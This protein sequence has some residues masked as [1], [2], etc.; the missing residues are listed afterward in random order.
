MSGYKT[1]KI[2][3]LA[4]FGLLLSLSKSSGLN[5]NDAKGSNFLKDTEEIADKTTPLVVVSANPKRE[6][7][8]SFFDRIVASISESVDDAFDISA[9]ILSGLSDI[10]VNIAV[11]IITAI[12]ESA[13][14]TTPGPT[15]NPI[16]SP[17]QTEAPIDPLTPAP[18][19]TPTPAPTDTPTTAPTGTPTTASTGTP[20]TSS[21]GTPTTAPTGT[22]STIP[23]LVPFTSSAPTITPDCSCGIGEFKVNLELKFVDFNSDETSFQMQNE[24]GDIF[25]IETGYTSI[26]LIEQNIFVNYEYCLPV[27]CYD[28]VINDS[29]GDGICCISDSFNEDNE[30]YYKASLYGW[31]E[32]FNGGEFGSQAIESFCGE[33]VCPFASHYPSTSPSTSSHP[34][35]SLLPSSLPSA[36]P[37]PSITDVD[38]YYFPQGDDCNNDDGCPDEQFCNYD[39]NYDVSP[40]GFCENC[41]SN[42][43]CD[44][45]GLPSLGVVDC[46][47]LCA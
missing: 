33:D 36:S 6:L 30:G 23:S 43:L 11:N 46:Q 27:G 5:I 28:F 40:S 10:V 41:V 34:S 38:D 14:V 9:I 31:K 17:T 18:T 15:L 7:Q 12:A 16:P 39:G 25:F 44:N 35:V 42:D 32:V 21:T 22:P 13:P 24:N 1:K 29:G 19:G 4:V 45:I 8:G 3:T 26:N 2:F 20:T 47:S 37:K